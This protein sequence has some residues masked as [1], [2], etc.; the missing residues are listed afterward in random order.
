MAQADWVIYGAYG[1]TGALIAEE[2][3]QRGLK[4]TLAGRREEPLRRLA[5]RLQLPWR[6]FDL[7][8]PRTLERELAGFKLALHCAGP[9]SRTAAPMMAAC[10]A[11]S[12]HY[13]DITGEIDVFAH[14]H[15]Q[16]AAARQAGV[17][18]V[19]G[20][21]FDVVPTDCLAATLKQA[22]PDASHLALA[23]EAGGG[24]S[25]G[26]ALTSV[27]GLSKGGR[28]RRDGELV[29]VPL[30][31]RSRDIDFGHGERCTVSIPWGDVYT[32]HVS[33]GIPNIEVYMS[34]SPATARRLRRLR[35]LRPVL[36]LSAVQSFLKA[37]V[38]A[39]SPGPSASTREGTES[40]V[41][42]EVTND[43][44]ERRIGRMITPNG[45][46]LT[47]I[48]ALGIAEHVLRHPDGEA[49]YR[50]PSQ[51]MGA[52]YAASLPGVSMSLD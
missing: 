38:A 32:A 45:Y 27:E 35:W 12:A 10:L 29:D 42:G 34:V 36:G 22:L 46:W 11:S 30:A 1:Y 44:G 39:G 41:W 40:R 31:W 24:P 4:P 43:A 3:V 13:L 49:G 9:F 7:D 52:G 17:L 28:I 37:R 33:T 20:V 51:L 48:A 5:E 47:T 6:A 2:A 8:D 26:T 50:T 16:D 25:R 15:A 14:G 23:F 19:P 18:I 21:G